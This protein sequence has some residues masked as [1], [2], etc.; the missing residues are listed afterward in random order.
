MC[1]C[2]LETSTGIVGYGCAAPD[3]EVTGETPAGVMDACSNVILPA[4]KGSDPLRPLMLMER[5]RPRLKAQ[6]AALAMADMALFD[7]LGKAAGSAA[8]QASRRI[9]GPH[10]HQHHHRDPARC[11]KPSPKPS[12]MRS[13]DFSP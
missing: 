5:I 7:I 3:L 2:A 12:T 9:P 11:E 13:R 4:F 10:A 1:S 8:L 6:P